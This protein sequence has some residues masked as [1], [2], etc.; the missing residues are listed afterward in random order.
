M[1]ELYE[2]IENL[3]QTLDAQPWIQEIEKIQR[4]I[5]KDPVL[6]RQIQMKEK[7]VQ[8]NSMIQEYRHLE[9]QCNFLILE[10][11]QYLKEKFREDF[12]ESN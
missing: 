3:K 12:H 10:I 4:E 6:L 1:E 9:N 5:L 7:Q 2:K 8:E 11:N